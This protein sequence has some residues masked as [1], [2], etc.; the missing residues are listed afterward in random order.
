ML[1][2]PERLRAA[3]QRWRLSVGD[4]LAGG[5]RSAVFSAQDEEG[6]ELVLKLPADERQA[7]SEAAAL[8]AWSSTGAAV[9][10][11]D[12]T[13][14]ALLLLRCQPGTPMPAATE[15][16]LADCVGIAGALLERLW[17]VE[18]G[19]YSF[20]M[21]E[22]AYTD[23]ERIAREDAAYEQAH[24]AEPARGLAGLKRLPAAAAAASALIRSTT[25]PSLLHGDF[26]TKN[27]IRDETSWEGYVSIDP[28]PSIGDRAFDVGTFA[29]YQPANLI[30]PTAELLATRCGLNPDR[31]LRWA[32]ISA[33]HQ[34]TQAWRKDQSQLELLV[35]SAQVTQLLAT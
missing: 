22:Q 34:T 10:L 13:G 3:A 5:S 32:A 8:R 7:A 31:S 14:D 12:A 19:G 11:V 21:L 24:R 26:L 28:L 1:E 25:K 23:N 27:V 29:A 18:P 4:P 16:S 6:R 17:A 15:E 20:R 30:L 9:R 2:L 35:T 33:V